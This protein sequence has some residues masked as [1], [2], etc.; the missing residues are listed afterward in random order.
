VVD[1][2]LCPACSKPVLPGQA[3]CPTCGA[4]LAGGSAPET[5][6]VDLSVDAAA[7]IGAAGIAS[8][9]RLDAVGLTPTAPSDPVLGGYVP[10]SGEPPIPSWALQPSGASSVARPDGPS[11]SVS[12]GAIPVSSVGRAAGAAAPPTAPPTAVRPA[13]SPPFA[14]PSTPRS[15]FAAPQRVAPPVVAVRA[16]A[17]ARPARKESTQELVAFGLVAAGAVMG[18]A[19]LFLPWTGVVGMGVGTTSPSPNQWG[20]S[21][22]AALPLFLLSALVLGGVTGSDRA[23]EKLPNLAPVIVKVT[24]LIMPMILGGLYLGVVLL[25]VTLPSGFGSGLLLGQLALLVGSGLLIAGSV[26]TLFYPTEDHG[27]SA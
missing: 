9:P 2:S 20:W 10:A 24:D 8:D 3:Y 26:T 19:S 11:M 5:A 7:T 23:I 4:P 22:P 21:L 13:G 15:P 12:V 16:Q 27:H 1:S 17:P 14:A 18:A 25:Y 6:P